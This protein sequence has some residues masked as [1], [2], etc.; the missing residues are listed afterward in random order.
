MRG[1]GP[2]YGSIPLSASSGRIN[3]VN[4][5]P[6]IAHNSQ[7]GKLAP[8]M[9]TTGSH[10]AAINAPAANAGHDK[11]RN[12]YPPR[13]HRSQVPDSDEAGS[14]NQFKIRHNLHQN[15]PAEVCAGSR[16]PVR[17]GPL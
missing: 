9:F 11:A 14:P 12:S 13:C 17:S 4:N 5:E 1:R 15:C 6:T 10:P 8:A 2:I 16:G 7:A 3:P